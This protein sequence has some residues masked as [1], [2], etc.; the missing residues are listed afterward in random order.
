MSERPHEMITRL[1]LTRLPA[2]FDTATPVRD[3]RATDIRDL[4]RAGPLRFLVARVGSSLR[5]VPDAEHF[6]FWKT[7]VQP[8]LADPDARVR[9]EEFEGGYC[10][11]ASQWS[12]GGP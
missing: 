10:Y 9:L 8:H 3:L 12:D 2:P 11:L 6:D 4:L 5:L 1:P 7:D